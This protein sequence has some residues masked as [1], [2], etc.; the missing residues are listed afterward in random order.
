MMNDIRMVQQ[1][2]IKTVGCCRQTKLE[3]QVDKTLYLLKQRSERDKSDTI[4]V[5]HYLS[6]TLSQ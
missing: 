3:A 6:S 4:S 2:T 5:V 1:K